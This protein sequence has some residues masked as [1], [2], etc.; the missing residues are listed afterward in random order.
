[1]RRLWR[2][3]FKVIRDDGW[4]EV[5]DG[6]WRSCLSDVYKRV[7]L[8]SQ[9]SHLRI[10]M[11]DPSLCL[12]SI[13]SSSK[14]SKPNLLQLLNAFWVRLTKCRLFIAIYNTSISKFL[15]PNLLGSINALTWLLVVYNTSIFKLKT[16]PSSKVSQSWLSTSL[17]NFF[18]LQKLIFI[19]NLQLIACLLACLIFSKHWLV[20]S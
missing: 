20:T 3:W 4:N 15:N 2:N 12:A 13:T 7:A 19:Q 10:C 16:Q 5:G 9:N 11:H 14:S 8:A 18:E 17:N 1:M 6:L